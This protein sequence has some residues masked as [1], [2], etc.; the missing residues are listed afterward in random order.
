MSELKS[1]SK[2]KNTGKLHF[3]RGTIEIDEHELH[4]I[5][6]EIQAEYD[7]VVAA[8]NKAAGNWAKADAELRENQGTRYHELFGTPE[9][10]ARTLSPDEMSCWWCLLHD[11]CKDECLID[12]RGRLLEW[13]RGESDE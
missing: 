3:W 1:L 8:I 6:D 12:E 11:H 2:L 9:R 10:A 7:R 13:L 5:C 4:T